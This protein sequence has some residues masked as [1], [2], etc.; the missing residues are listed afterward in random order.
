MGVKLDVEASSQYALKAWGNPPV[1][2][3]LA[4]LDLPG[5]SRCKEGSRSWDH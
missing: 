1:T 2:P 5:R 4:L 3:G